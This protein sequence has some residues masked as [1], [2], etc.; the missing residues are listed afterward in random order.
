MTVLAMHTTSAICS[1]YGQ[2]QNRDALRDYFEYAA[3]GVEVEVGLSE[4]SFGEYLVENQVVSRYQL[5]RALQLQ[6]R[7]TGVRLGAAVAALGYASA[8]TVE[9]HYLRFS[10]LSTID[11]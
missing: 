7:M 2:A 3:A 9:H 11:V 6:D 1:G 8:G 5:F 10:Q 4:V